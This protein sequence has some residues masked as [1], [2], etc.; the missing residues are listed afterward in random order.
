MKVSSIHL[1][2]PK[3]FGIEVY[4]SDCA[5]EEY[6]VKECKFIDHKYDWPKNKVKRFEHKEYAFKFSKHELRMVDLK[7]ALTIIEKSFTC[8][9]WG[10]IGLGTC[11]DPI[12]FSGKLQIFSL[13][14]TKN[15][16]ENHLNQVINSEIKYRK[17][18]GKCP[19]FFRRIPWELWIRP[20]VLW[21]P[22]T[23]YAEKRDFDFGYRKTRK[24]TKDEIINNAILYTRFS[25]GFV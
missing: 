25:T 23:G 11:F 17:K 5:Y 18:K 7:S 1:D 12:R 8:E 4:D 10:K 13:L 15:Y 21:Y 24:P 19:V 9:E 2:W 22:D 6:S 3:E 20:S 14:S 16:N